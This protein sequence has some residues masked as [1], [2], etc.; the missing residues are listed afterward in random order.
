MC[1]Y[2]MKLGLA[3]LSKIEIVFLHQTD[4][5]ILLKSFK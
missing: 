5:L 4:S 2:I 1:I 3:Y